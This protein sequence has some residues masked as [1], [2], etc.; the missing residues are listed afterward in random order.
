MTI[1]TYNEDAIFDMPQR[2]RANFINSLSGFK[3]AN[4]V[5]TASKD[6]DLNLAIISSVFH[7][8]AKPPLLGMI[9][10]PHTV[11]RDTLDNIKQTG[12]YTI[13]HVHSGIVKQ[14]HQC[15]ARYAPKENEFD[16][17]GLTA[18]MSN[19][20]AVPFVGESKI[21]M[22]LKVEQTNLIEANQTE[23]VIG[24]IV[25]VIIDGDYLLEDG[26]L[27]IEKADSIAVSCLD[28]YHQTNRIDRF[29]YAKPEKT[30]RSISATQAQSK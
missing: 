27:D 16:K 10:R 30:L 25:E 22:A 23:L 13:N 7:V 20:L 9:M 21:K 18:Q 2:V 11:I 15:S 26:Y 28:S 19:T 6:G 14:A 12:M 4:L 5:G 24:R 29:S 17:V 1:T 8:G 3:S